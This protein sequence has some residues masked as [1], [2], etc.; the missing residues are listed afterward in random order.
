MF[1][2]APATRW[3]YFAYPLGLLGWL[4]LTGRDRAAAGRLPAAGRLTWPAPV[5][6]RLTPAMAGLV[7]APGTNGTST[8]PGA[9]GSDRDGRG[10][11]ALRIAGGRRFTGRFGPMLAQAPRQADQQGRS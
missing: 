1:T 5:A 3:G 2:L 6:A 9:P 7:A 11:R 4:G 10:D 8:A